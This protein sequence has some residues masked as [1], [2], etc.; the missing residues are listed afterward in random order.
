M[1]YNSL[2]YLLVFLP[3]VMLL[4]QLLPQKHRWK[5]LL[6]ASYVFFFLLSRKLIIYLLFSTGCMHYMGLWLNTCDR[7][8]EAFRGTEDFHAQKELTVRKK[9]GVLW[10]GVAVQIGVL[11]LLKYFNFVSGN[12]NILLSKMSL[13]FTFPTLKLSVPIGISFFTMQAVSYIVDVYKKKI[14]ADRNLGRLALYMAFFPSIMEGP[15]CRY[16]E[17]AEALYAGERLTYHNIAFGSQRIVWGLFKKVVLADRLSPLVELIFSKYTQYG[18]ITVLLGA[19]C[20]T[21]QL[22]ADFSGCIDM[23][24]GTAEM[25]GVRLPENFRQPFFSRTASEFWRRWHITLGAWFKDY[26]F[27]PLSLTKWIKNMGKKARQKFGRHVGPVIQTIVPLLAV[28]LSNGIWHGTGWNYIFFG[29]YYFVLILTGNLLEPLIGK[30]TDLLHVSRKSIGWRA[31]QTVKM[32]CIIVTGE[33]FFKAAS[34]SAGFHMFG[35]IFKAFDLSVLSNGSLLNLK[36]SIKD[37]V[38]VAVGY[39]IVLAVGIV[40]EKGIHIRERAASWPVILRWSFYYAAILLV[41]IFG[42][43][44]G[45]YAPVDPLY[46]SF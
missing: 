15:I 23:T 45:S 41:F 22:Y 33:L 9:R 46:A 21:L 42:A 34:L 7:D 8:L 25:F 39:L 43:Y 14:P 40:H 28:W 5:L 36:L 35:S 26:I 2:L 37:F 11:L 29:L 27:Y 1:Q 10:L 44:G 13:A 20:Y 18:G 3:V 31:M 32:F 12:L 17:T 6:A 19:V 30:A 16:S 4:Y 24:I 38:V